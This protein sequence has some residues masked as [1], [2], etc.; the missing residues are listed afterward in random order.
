MKDYTK[1]VLYFD[2]TGTLNSFIRG[3]YSISCPITQKINKSFYFLCMKFFAVVFLN[4]N[5]I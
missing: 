3:Y 1:I 2:S 5:V 4:P